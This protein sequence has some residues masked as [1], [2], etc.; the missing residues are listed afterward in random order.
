[1]TAQ[2]VVWFFN[3]RYGERA[4]IV[5]TN[6]EI[7]IFTKKS[8][9]K[10]I[11]S[12]FPRFHYYTLFHYNLKSKTGYHKQMSGRTIEFLTFCACFHDELDFVGPQEFIEFERQYEMYCYGRELYERACA[13]EWLSGESLGVGI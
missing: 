5:E 1:M 13:F 6:D 10:I 9:W 12:D 7:N 11:K 8:K 2:E 4:Y 3:H